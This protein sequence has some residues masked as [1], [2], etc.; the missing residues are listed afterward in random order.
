MRMTG[1]VHVAHARDV[2]AA[3]LAAL[4]EA[5]GW[6]V[7]R[8]GDGPRSLALAD[9][10]V[11]DYDNAVRLATETAEQRPP[12]RL[13]VVTHRD[14]EWEVRRALALS[15][16]GYLLEDATAA[17]VRNAVRTVMFGGR[18]LCPA[19]TERMA[20]TLD[21]QPLTNRES[22]VLRLLARGHCN[23][24]IARDLGIGLGTVKTHVRGVMNKL[25]ATART[26]AVV[27]AAQRGLVGIDGV[28]VGEGAM[29]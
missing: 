5:D 1:R 13:L 25:G 8:D 16:K 3:G 17:E 14:R 4:L 29:R 12:G 7:S 27:V 20:D 18:Y 23:K 19:A 24:L 21:R 2:T 22:D 9:V 10:V 6:L 15:V 26:H 11:T 28:E